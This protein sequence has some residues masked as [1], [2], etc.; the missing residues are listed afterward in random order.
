M[1]YLPIFT[2]AFLFLL[3]EKNQHRKIYS[4]LPLHAKENFLN[5]LGT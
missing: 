2:E 1:K 3:K 4:L 5:K